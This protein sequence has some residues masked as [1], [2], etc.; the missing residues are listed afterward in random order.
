MAAV[1]VQNE[2]DDQIRRNGLI[3]LTQE[4]QKLLVA[5]P[6]LAGCQHRTV[7]HVERG[8]QGGRAMADVVGV[9]PWT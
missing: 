1:V 4:R 6:G 7:E 2:V 3:D 5:V 9:T 8:K